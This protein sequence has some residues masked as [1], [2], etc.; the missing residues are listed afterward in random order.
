MTTLPDF[1]ELYKPYSGHSTLEET[2]AWMK[3][4]CE[5][6]GISEEVR[7]KA[8]CLTFLEMA[9]GKEFELDGGDTGFDGMPHA[10]QNIYML[11]K[12]IKLNNIATKA[13][14]DSTE[15]LL[16]SRIKA[17]V[18][19]NKRKEYWRHLKRESPVLKM[20]TK[21]KKVKKL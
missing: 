3:R 7:Q 18:K 5:S 1:K 12:A 8:I 17:Y 4:E 21:S 15:G 19:R 9:Q 14:V 10:V 16:Q 13:F 20:F 2:L 6:K 11:Q